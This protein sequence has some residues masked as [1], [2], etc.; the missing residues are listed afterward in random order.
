[1]DG[2]QSNVGVDCTPVPV[3][4]IVCGL[5]DALSAIER[6][7]WRLPIAF[8]VKAI[9]TNSCCSQEESLRYIRH[10][11]LHNRPRLSQKYSPKY[12]SEK[13]FHC[14]RGL[15]SQSNFRALFGFQS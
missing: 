7:A 12:Q 2:F 10:W 9:V 15:Q 11:I 1:V 4:L 5:P 6:V 3:K 13:R 14:S 8:G